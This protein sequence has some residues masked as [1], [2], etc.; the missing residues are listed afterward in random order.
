MKEKQLLHQVSRESYY[1]ANAFQQ[2]SH[3][4][5][6]IRCECQKHEQGRKK[7]EV[8]QL[9]DQNLLHSCH[10]FHCK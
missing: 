1:H 10:I 6:N 3:C 7:G 2:L 8:Y 4:L 5:K 9:K